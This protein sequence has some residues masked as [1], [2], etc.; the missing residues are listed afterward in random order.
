MEQNRSSAFFAAELKKKENQ[1]CF[2]CGAQKPAWATVTYAVYLCLGCSSHHRAL[3]VHISFVRST[4]LDTW[5]EEQLERMAH[6]GNAAAEKYLSRGSCHGADEARLKYSSTEAGKYKE[7]LDA[8]AGVPRKEEPGQ[9]QTQPEQPQRTNIPI[10]KKNLGAM[11][12]TKEESVEPP[13]KEP[14]SQHKKILKK[15]PEPKQEELPDSDLDRLG[16]ALNIQSQKTG[17]TTKEKKK[18]VSSV[19]SE[20][21]T[22]DTG[23]TESLRRENKIKFA[24]AKSISS[25]QYF[26]KE[27]EDEKAP[28]SK[29]MSAI[30]KGVEKTKEKFDGYVKGYKTKNVKD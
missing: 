1:T 26:S 20:N 15:E 4:T 19:S 2:D 27:P 22:Q 9:K 29:T 8:C 18:G 23:E 16:I 21:I 25:N 6:G 30:K 3:G 14:P 7:Y 28:P 17:E 10:R 11:K 5:K 13:I 24:S 12:I